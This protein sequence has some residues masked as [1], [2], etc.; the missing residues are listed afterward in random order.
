MTNTTTEQLDQVVVAY[1]ESASLVL[2]VAHQTE[3]EV[4]LHFLFQLVHTHSR[5]VLGH[6][7]DGLRLLTDFFS[8]GPDVVICL[9]VPSIDERRG[10]VYI[11][12]LCP[13]TSGLAGG[14]GGLRA[15]DWLCDSAGLWSGLCAGSCC[16]AG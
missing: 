14:G 16:G 1:R 8:I 2:V 15:A 7:P 10:V 9:Y 11:N 5:V 12:P 13:P 6:T 4:T 3:A